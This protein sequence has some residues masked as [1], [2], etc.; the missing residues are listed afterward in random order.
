M[1]RLDL[2]AEVSETVKGNFSSERLVIA[3]FEEAERMLKSSLEQLVRGKFWGLLNPPLNIVVQQLD[4]TDGGLSPTERRILMN[5]AERI[6]GRKIIIEDRQEALTW[7]QAKG[8]LL[9]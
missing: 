6:G 1:V 7:E 5:V 3:D 8:I 4:F 2:S 9:V